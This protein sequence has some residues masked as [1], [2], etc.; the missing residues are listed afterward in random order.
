MNTLNGKKI[1]II[2]LVL[3]LTATTFMSIMPS[4]NAAVTNYDT[5]AFVMVSPNPVGVNQEAL[6]TFR[7][8]KTNPLTTG[9]FSGERWQGL[10]VRI[11][12]PDGI[13]ENKGPYEADPTGGSWFLYTP[14]LTGTYQFQCNFAGQNVNVSATDQRW[15]KPSTSSILT[16]T[17]QQDPIPRYERSPPLPTDAWTRPINSENKGW[18][19]VAD[20][21]LMKGYDRT[22]ARPF[23]GGTAFA[24]YSS[25]PNSAH[26][27]WKDPIYFGGITGGKFGDASFYTGLAYEQFFNAMI[28]QGRLFYT[29][30]GPS[31]S[32]DSYGTRVLDLQTGKEI[33][34]LDGINIEFAQNLMIDIPN[35][36]GV[37]PFLWSISGTT[38]TMYDSFNFMPI[39]NITNVP[40]GTTSFGPNGE[41]LRYQFTGTAANRR[42][43]MW[44][45]TQ[46]IIGEGFTEYW[47]P[48]VGSVIN[49]SRGI[50]WNVS[51]PNIGGS[52]SIKM[53]GEDVI[54]AGY[55]VSTVYP[56][57]YAHA[58]YPTAI[59]RLANGSY[60]NSISHLWAQ[61]RTNIHAFRERIGRNIENGVYTQYDEPTMTLHGYSANTGAELWVTD[62]LPMGWG[63]F[64]ASQHVAY[65]N[66]YRA[67]YDGYMRAYSATNGNLLWEYY[68]GQP[69]YL[70]NAYGVYPV[71][72]GF[73]IADKKVF[74][75]AGEHSPD[76][77]I[78]RGGMMWAINAETGECL[79]NITGRFRN[80]SV[81]DGILVALNSMDGV[82]YAFGKGASATT[83]STPIS[84]IT[85]GQSLI[86][87]G[88][89][90]DQSPAQSNTPAI[91]D[92][93]MG[94]WMEYLHMQ[95]TM[96]TNATGVPVVLTAT[97]SNGVTYNIGITTTDIGGSYGLK[98]TP[99]AED[100]Y[101]IMATFEGTNS[102]SSSYATTY[103]AVDT[104]PSSSPTSTATPTEAPIS[105]PTSTAS[106]TA[107]PSAGVDNP[108]TGISTE[109]LLIA[110]A[111]AVIVIAVIAA[112]LVLRKRQ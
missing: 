20:D 32:S 61:N 11:V 101:Q 75:T 9:S 52:Q 62:S 5:F 59:D 14:S 77:V 106:P 15:Y 76:A 97:D 86:I 85:Q 29:V 83:I 84:A 45:S 55:Q 3:L 23:A 96:P 65:G 47:S 6:V 94:Q 43:I 78:W 91:S 103:I 98:W 79:W 72:E 51:I 110:G 107:S 81:A 30:H 42:L 22:E 66:A 100:T 58:A 46:A 57:V 64:G 87:T 63:L 31:T 53:I 37:L 69:G 40:S 74:V 1:A 68:L 19:Q 28:Q 88:T 21:W 71:Q 39:L 27:L 95:K 2:S 82:A 49:G 33:A 36:H 17:V 41:L 12:R 105:T 80:P 10:T 92:E 70:E 25:A 60:P 35:E 104:A 38:W 18:W 44:N 73:T 8:D 7:I 112:A 24:P 108:G 16:V 102:Y 99:P 4:V 48:R 54:I 89:V 111:A 13:V 26:I 67:G 50:Q 34:Y 109:T 90:T 93:D 56:N